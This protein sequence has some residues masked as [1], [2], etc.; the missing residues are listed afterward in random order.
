MKMDSGNIRVFGYIDPNSLTR[1]ALFG[2]PIVGHYHA[3]S[4]F[5][6]DYALIIGDE[7]RPKYFGARLITVRLGEKRELTFYW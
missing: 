2:G 4:R 3:N 5:S 7:C 1:W 6:F